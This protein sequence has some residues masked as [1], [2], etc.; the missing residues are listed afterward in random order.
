MPTGKTYYING[1]KERLSIRK[2]N[3]NKIEQLWRAKYS[4]VRGGGRKDVHTGVQGKEVYVQSYG[5]LKGSQQKTTRRGKR[6]CH[7][8]N[9]SKLMPEKRTRGDTGRNLFFAS[10]G[11]NFTQRKGRWGNRGG[12]EKN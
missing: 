8:R 9:L 6:L 5:S 1:V 2:N 11:N 4:C 12:N 3:S 10:P 7:R